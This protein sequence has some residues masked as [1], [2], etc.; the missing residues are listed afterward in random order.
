MM[1]KIFSASSDYRLVENDGLASHG[2][3][4]DWFISEFGRPA[5]TF[6]IGKGENP[7]PLSDFEQIYE[8][9]EE[10]LLLAALM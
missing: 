6:E 3:F 2:G 9:L 5:F 10:T 8:K 7:L 1:A 4:K